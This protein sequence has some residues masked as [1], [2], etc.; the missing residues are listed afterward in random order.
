MKFY[1]RKI[2]YFFVRSVIFL[3]SGRRSGISK[4]SVINLILKLLGYKYIRWDV[5]TKMNHD[6]E[7]DLNFKDA[8]SESL[9]IADMND[10]DF[11][12]KW[13]FHISSWCAE[14][15]TRIDGDFI[16]L[17][18]YKGR[19]AISNIVY[20]NFWKI[21]KKYYLVDSFS[22]LN[23]DS[24]SDLEVQQYGSS[25]KE[26]YLYESC[27]DAFKNYENVVI[28][29]GVVPEI[30]PKIDIKA[31]AYMHIDMNAVYPEIEAL[32]FFYNKVSKGGVILLDDYGQSALHIHQKKAFD[33]LAESLGV[34]I[35]SLPTGQ[36]I[37]IKP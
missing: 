35:L 24:S 36:G 21:D 18:V 33:E 23:S 31:I 17:G 14:Y 26:E 4:Y 25:Y 28:V 2:Y 32:N 27:V 5:I 30:L 15:A 10:N 12:P 20:T 16:E 29:K 7:Y 13:Q 19:H 3:F 37:I 22:G 11:S 9:N 34:K 1:F 6:F 8:Y